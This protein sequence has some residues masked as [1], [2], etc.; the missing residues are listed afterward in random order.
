LVI[1]NYLKESIMETT[2]YLGIW[3]DHSSANCM[4]LTG[5]RLTTTEISSEFT[6]EEREESRTHGEKKMHNKEQHMTAK[7]FKEISNEILKADEVLLFGP[8]DAKLEL[9]NVL[10]LDH[11]FD[12]KKIAAEICVNFNGNQQLSFFKDYFE[13]G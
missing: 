2:N 3:M 8:T 1:A 13:L 7:F 9:W 4:L 6:H 5:V 10:K 12:N 11:H